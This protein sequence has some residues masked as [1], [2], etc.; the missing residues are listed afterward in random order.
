MLILGTILLGLFAIGAFIVYLSVMVT[1]FVLGIIFFGFAFL[2]GYIVGDPYL[3][4]FGA[5]P[6]TWAVSWWIG[7]HSEKK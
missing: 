4:F 3:G 5:I 7:R 2:I 1:L 6:A